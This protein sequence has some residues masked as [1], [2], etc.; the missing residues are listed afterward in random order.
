MAGFSALARYTGGPID[1]EH[2]PEQELMLPVG[3]RSWGWGGGDALAGLIDREHVPEQ[4]LMEH[5][6]VGL[7]RQRCWSRG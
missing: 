5:W 3:V 6:G 2:V 7:G 1:R 4:E